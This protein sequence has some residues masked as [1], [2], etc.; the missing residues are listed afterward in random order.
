MEFTITE[1]N[2]GKKCIIYEGYKF[3]VDTTLSDGSFSWRCTNGKCKARVKTDCEIGSIV[4]VQLQHNHE[5]DERK[6]ERQQL[7]TAVKR[8]ESDDMTARPAKIIRTELCKVTENNLQSGDLKCLAQ[9]IYRERRKQ[10]PVLPKNRKEV[11]QA[12]ESMNT[13]TSKGEEFVLEN[14]PDTGIVILS[15]TTNLE[16]LVTSAEEIFIDGTFKSCPKYFY[17]LYSIHGLCNGHYIPLVY[18]LLAGKS[19]EIY[20]TMW[21]CLHDICVSKNLQLQPSVL[22]VDFEFPIL[23]ILKETFPDAIIKCCRF[24][25]GQAWWRKIQNL[26]LSK[27]Y[28]DKNSDIGQWLKLSYGLHFIDPADIE[29]CFIEELMSCTPQKEKCTNYADYLV[30]NYVTPHSKFP[31][32]LWAEVPSNDKR[33]NNAAESFHAHFNAQ[34]YKA[35][36]TIFI[37]MDVVKKL[38]ATTY[39]KIRSTGMPAVPKKVDKEKCEYA[40]TQFAKYKSQ[41]INRRQY[42]QSMGCSFMARTDLM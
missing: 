4:P 9:S 38:Q 33:T 29:D 25:L 19:E 10:Y 14:N 26:G 22:H 5:N 1:T 23:T 18:V 20:R 30:D 37:F 27:E 41:D 21:K 7:R 13:T 40:I 2:K 35:H 12:L 17:Q 24:H 8:K 16:F 15:C 28:K 34:F 39:L 3:R 6:L 36:P 31:P 42:L 32:V 11:H